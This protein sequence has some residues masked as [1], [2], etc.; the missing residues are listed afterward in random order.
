ML[1]KVTTAALLGIEPYR[2]DVEVDLGRGMMVFQTVGLAAGAVREA[3]TRVKS[4]LE[5]CGFGL[6]RKRITVNLAPAHVRKDGTAFDL[7]IAVGILA[8][9]GKIPK[10]ALEGTLFAGEL[11]L[12]GALRPIRGALAIAARAARLRVKRLILPTRNAN[13]AAVVPGVEVLGAEHLTQVVAALAG[14]APL[15]AGRVVQAALQRDDHEVDLSDVRGQAGPRR[16]LEVAAAGG[17]NLLLIGPPGAGKTMLARRLPSITPE[18]THAERL[19]TSIVAS[20]AGLLRPDA[21]LVA[22]RPFRAPHSSVSDAGMVGGGPLARPGEVSLAHNGVLFLDE[23]PEFRRN[24]LES[25]RQ[26][27]E[28][29]QVA[30]SR[31]QT[32]CVYP[33]RFAL[34]ASMNP[35]ACGFYGHPRKSCECHPTALQ[36]YRARISGPLLDRIDLQVA[37]EPV[38]AAA[39][40]DASPGE[41]SATVRRR[42]ERARRRQA[43]RLSGRRAQCNGQMSAADVRALCR[44]DAQGSRLLRRAIEAMSL[45]ARA[46]D[47]VLK[48]A[49]TLADLDERAAIGCDHLGVALQFR[50]LDRE[51][52]R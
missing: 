42:V 12:D 47:R 41:A 38:D 44:L 36:R 14:G 40:R 10:R 1:A 17:H 34:V 6:P 7:P 33:A 16:A 31:A 2:V 52:L 25:L 50:Q 51:A 18:M 9:D 4:A 30:V 46:H 23:A 3:R 29:G 48:V 11:S 28:D 19:E 13:E 32:R 37:V 27:L 21:G 35:C 8:A 24:V 45:S 15:E 26:P 39:L 20:V 22:Q 43:G 49:R 5:N